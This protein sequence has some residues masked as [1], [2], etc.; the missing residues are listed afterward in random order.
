MM[1]AEKHIGRIGVL[2]VALGIGTAWR[3]A[4]RVTMSIGIAALVVTAAAPASTPSPAVKLS[5]DSTALLVCFQT[6][7]TFNDAHVQAIKNQIIAPTHP[8][9]DIDYVLLPTRGE[10]WPLTG[11]FRALEALGFA[12]SG[13]PHP[14]GDCRPDFW[15]DQP[16]W[17]LSGLFDRTYDQSVAGGAV[18]LEAAMAAAGNDHLVIYGDDQGANVANVM[19][20]KLA[21][22][23]PI[24]T[25]AP[26]IDF[27]T[28]GSPNVPNGGIH[29][30]FPGLFV[31][32]G[33]TFDG[34]ESINT[35]FHTDVIIRQY[36]GITDFPLYPVN[37]I[38]TANALLGVLYVHPFPYDVSLAPDP[39]GIPAP[40]SQ[41][42]D[43]S[44]HF[45]ET[46]NL[47]LFGPLRTLGVPES[48]ID[49]VEPFFRVLVEAGY[50]RTIPTGEPTP[51]R[52]IP[53]LKPATLITD[54][55]TAIGEGINNAG[56]NLGLPTVPSIPVPMTL[57]EPAIETATADMSTQAMSSS[58]PTQTHQATSTE[59]ITG[60]RQI[61]TDT[62][63]STMVTDFANSLATVAPP[64]PV[65]DADPPTSEQTT[66][67]T[68][69]STSPGKL[70]DSTIATLTTASA[71][72]PSATA[73]PQDSSTNATSPKRSQRG[74]RVA[75]HRPVVRDS[76][77]VGQQLAG[78]SHGHENDQ[79][80]TRTA[81]D[82]AHSAEV[83]S[84][85]VSSWSN[86]SSAGGSSGAHSA[87]SE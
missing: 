74:D 16:L 35:Q 43:T 73:T 20:R 57:A 50:D 32:Y 54:L 6:C 38:A 82:G 44:Y 56:A 79:P 4:A 10:T 36:D 25:P 23:Y 85:T 31:P 17:K 58:T 3:N 61:S 33:W 28:T 77:R 29:A 47:P 15:P 48:L 70:A 18:D 53:P 8:G 26:D 11:V 65:T 72:E 30:R 34:P 42:G 13:C 67:D 63:Q 52:L 39:T 22:R 55:A 7:T 2:A 49:V 81:V 59:A 84:T 14:A 80:V 86:S 62:A 24:G 75:T 76:L 83:S 69:Q 46:K 41:Y 40:A 78:L 45:F 21:E 68:G 64:N 51:A 66:T 37:V 27:A 5:A 87:G 19:K 71:D 60:A 1:S 9:Q 12:D